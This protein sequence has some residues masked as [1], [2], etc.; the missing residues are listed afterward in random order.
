[1]LKLQRPIVFFDTET[2]GTD[3][4][5]DRIVEISLVKFFNNEIVEEFTTLVNPGVKIP[6]GATKVH[7]ITDDDVQNFKTFKDISVD[8][9]FFIKDCDLAGFNIISFDVPLLFN[10]FLRADIEWDYTGINFLD[11]FTIYR[12]NEKR[13][14]SAA[15]RFYLKEEHEGAHGA[16][17]DTKATL[18]IFVSQI[19]KYPDLPTSVEE[20]ALYSNNDK[21]ILDLS[22]KFSL[23]EDNEVIF[24]FGKNQ[25]KPALSDPSY[26]NWMLN[27]NFS[28]DTKRIIKQLLNRNQEAFL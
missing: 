1:M 20:L 27:T 17:A 3:V 11:A 5:N 9:L 23:N 19:I 24:N 28:P 22:G 13:D 10:E 8:I 12:R 15:V 26:L 25:G 16:L 6:P 7:H 14:L 18:R 21:K 2:T 4:V